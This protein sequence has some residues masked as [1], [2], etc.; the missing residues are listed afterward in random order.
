MGAAQPTAWVARERQGLR[1]ALALSCVWLVVASVWIWGYTLDDAFI[2]FRYAQ[3]LAAGR[4]LVF[5]EGERVEGYTNFLWIIL[6]AAVP[7]LSAHV[8]L[9]AKVLGILFNVLTLVVC[10]FLGGTTPSTKAPFYGGAL[11]LIGSNAALIAS[12]VDGLETPL[13]TLLM[14]SAVLAYLKGLRAAAPREQ[15]AWLAAASFLFGLLV[16]TRPDGALTYAL[17]WL[18]AAWRFRF[19]RRQLALFTIPFLLLFAPYFLW[20]WQYYG[21]FFPNTFY[22]KHGGSAMLFSRGAARIRNFLGLQGGGLLAAGAV[23][24]SAALF[25]SSESTVLALAVLSRLLFELWSGGEWSGYFRFLVPTLPFLWILIERLLAGGVRVAGLGRRG[26]CLLAGLLALMLANQMLHFLS[27]RRQL[28]EPH[29]IGFERA[30]VALGKWLKTNSPFNATIA[31][32]DIGAVSFYSGLRVIDTAGLANTHVA[33]LPGVLY[34]KADPGYVLSQKPQFIVLLVRRCD[35]KPEDFYAAMDKAIA[36]EAEFKVQYG[37]VNCWEYNPDYHL[38]LF[39]RRASPPTPRASGAGE[40]HS[41]N[42]SF[43]C[44]NSGDLGTPSLWID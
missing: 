42:G 26:A 3:N 1:L 38:L 29:R 2:G 31:V 9:A 35:P 34:G 18:H 37:R 43:L 36:A 15:A 39:A 19:R 20:R 33:R 6:L 11:L 30:H 12:G 8:V 40:L 7:N 24:L 32:G 5:N 44:L 22:A 21:A 25:A 28:F 13:F 27:L 10:F 17:V 41:Q 16:L 14:S 4:G 23:A